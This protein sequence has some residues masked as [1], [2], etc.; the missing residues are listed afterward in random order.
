VST[1][2]L[3]GSGRGDPSLRVTDVVDSRRLAFEQQRRAEQEAET[4]AL[5][6]Q[7]EHDRFIRAHTPTPPPVPTD[8]VEQLHAQWKSDRWLAEVEESRRVP[9]R[10]AALEEWGREAELEMLMSPPPPAPPTRFGKTLSSAQVA[11][12]AQLAGAFAAKTAAARCQCGQ[13]HAGGR[14]IYGYG[15]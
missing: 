8:P 15:G 10:L 12:E 4:K 14:C 5:V 6:D 2:I 13:Y 1:E 11:H 9:E 3:K 7:I